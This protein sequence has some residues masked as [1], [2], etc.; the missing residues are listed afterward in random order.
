[1]VVF[2]QTTKLLLENLVFGHEVIDS[3]LLLPADPAGQYCCKESHL[4]NHSGGDSSNSKA[5]KIGRKWG[6]VQKGAF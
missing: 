5:Q 2:Q 1:M 6:L 3:L 4:V